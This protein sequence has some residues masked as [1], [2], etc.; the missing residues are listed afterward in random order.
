MQRRRLKERRAAA[1]QDVPETGDVEPIIVDVSG[2]R[3]Q[4]M[5]NGKIHTIPEGAVVAAYFLDDGTEVFKAYRLAEGDDDPDLIY[6]S[7]GYNLV[8]KGQANVYIKCAF[9]RR[10]RP[11]QRGKVADI[12]FHGPVIVV[13]PHEG[14]EQ[15]AKSVM[16]DAGP[17]PRK[18]K[19]QKKSEERLGREDASSVYRPEERRRQ[20]EALLNRDPVK[21]EIN[22]MSGEQFEEFMA[23]LFHQRGYSVQTTTGSGD[24]GVD[25][26]L[27]VDDRKVAVQ[28]KR[29]TA[30][31]GNRVISHTL[32]GMLHYG[33]QEAWVVTT[34]SFTPKAKEMARSTGV[35]LI[36]GNELAEW[37][38]GLSEE[39]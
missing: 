26:L 33:A 3:I 8:G 34:G 2:Q 7:K 4:V 5:P 19:T 1:S 15:P 38:E 16:G 31:V 10:V 18:Q 6:E 23:E 32:G 12:R 36:D 29:W 35:R 17:P 20:I 13:K 21:D 39:Q 14:K 24:Q 27:D 30:P 37:L 22:Y 11:W 9:G 28:L 25:L